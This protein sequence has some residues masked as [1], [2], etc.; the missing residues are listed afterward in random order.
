MRIDDNLLGEDMI[1]D[2]SEFTPKE[3]P[4]E[5]QKVLHVIDRLSYVRLPFKGD[6]L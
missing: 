2:L 3:L 5:Y 6:L 4:I 1:C